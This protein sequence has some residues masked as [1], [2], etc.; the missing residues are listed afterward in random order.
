MPNLRAACSTVRPPL[1]LEPANE[2]AV[3]QHDVPLSIPSRARSV[4]VACHAATGRGRRRLPA[5]R[6]G[7]AQLGDPIYRQGVM[8][9]V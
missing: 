7:Q 2:V 1:P 9:G 4:T 6:N 5:S 3:H 8:R